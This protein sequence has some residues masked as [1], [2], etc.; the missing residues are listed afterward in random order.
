MPYDRSILG[1]QA[2]TAP[3]P[4][5]TAENR[6]KSP[7]EQEKGNFDKK[8]DKKCIKCRKWLNRQEFFG[9]HD[10]STDGYQSICKTCKGEANKDARRRNITARIRHHVATRCLDQLGDRAPKGL[11]KNIEDYLGYKFKVLIRHLRADLRKREGEDRKLIDALNEGYHVDH[12]YPLSRFKVLDDDGEVDWDMFREC[13][14]IENLSAIPAK[15]NL[16]KGAKVIRLND[17][18]D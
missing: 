1:I 17:T 12:I 6:Q 9:K 8:T 15:E 18:D 16:Q 11:T 5:K 4:S 13:W 14:R 2:K 10:T 7:P 3:N